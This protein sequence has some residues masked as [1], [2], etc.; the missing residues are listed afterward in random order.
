M[1]CQYLVGPSSAKNIS[2]NFELRG[3]GKEKFVVLNMLVE[4]EQFCLV[5]R[6]IGLEKGEVEM[7]LINRNVD[8]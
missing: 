6:V 3:I 4:G 5:W 1:M 8:D 2:D 7:V